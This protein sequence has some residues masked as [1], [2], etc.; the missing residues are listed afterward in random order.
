MPSGPAQDALHA[1]IGDG[2]DRLKFVLLAPFNHCRKQQERCFLQAI[3]GCGRHVLRV[4]AETRALPDCDVFRRSPTVQQHRKGI[5]Q[6]V[7][8]GGWQQADTTD[9][10]SPIDAQQIS[11]RQ[12]VVLI[13]LE[14]V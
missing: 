9:N 12:G 8:A 10:I 5:C 1:Q 13:D 6:H 4:N 11:R 7:A 2:R 3:L 14:S